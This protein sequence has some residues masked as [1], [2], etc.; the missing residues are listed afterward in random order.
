MIFLIRYTILFL[1]LKLLS[2]CVYLDKSF[3]IYKTFLVYKVFDV[4]IT[5][6]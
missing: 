1:L 4:S 6:L 2:C 3:L 5:H